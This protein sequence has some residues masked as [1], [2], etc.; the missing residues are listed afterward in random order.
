MREFS[1]QTLELRIIWPRAWL[2][3]FDSPSSPARL[4]SSRGRRTR[5]PGPRSFRILRR[6]IALPATT[7]PRKTNVARLVIPRLPRNGAARSTINR[8]MIPFSC[9]RTPSNRKR[10]A[11]HVTFRKRI[12][13][14][15]PQNRRA[16]SAWDVSR[17]MPQPEKSS[18]RTVPWPMRPAMPRVP[19][20]SFARR[21]YAMGA[22]NSISPN[23][24]KRR[25][26]EHATNTGPRV[27]LRR[28]ANRAT[29]LYRLRPTDRNITI[30]IFA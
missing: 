21:R 11:E 28:V 9:E 25:C 6:K 5:R 8:G 4:S 20:R 13:R 17:A 12:R 1:F 22:I 18:R 14:Q 30:M 24:N 23:R 27:L 26:K 7:L 10:F 29:C 3:R 19:M 15:R 16:D 2:F